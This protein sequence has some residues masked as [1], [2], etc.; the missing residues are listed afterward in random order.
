MDAVS[1]LQHRTLVR[2][3]RIYKLSPLKRGIDTWSTA[4]GSQNKSCMIIS[5]CSEEV[6][7]SRFL[8]TTDFTLKSC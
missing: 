3:K 2:E 4:S 6:V 7:E 1:S 5:F 8:L